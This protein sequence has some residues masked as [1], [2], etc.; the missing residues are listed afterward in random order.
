MD[1]LTLSL[2]Q[3]GEVRIERPLVLVRHKR[4]EKF[5]YRPTVKSRDVPL[6]YI[7]NTPLDS[8]Q[9]LSISEHSHTIPGNSSSAM[10]TSKAWIQFY[11]KSWTFNYSSIVATNVSITDEQGQRKPLF[12]VHRLPA[13]VAGVSLY[14]IENGNSISVDT[15]YY[16]DLS[17]KLFFTNYQNFFDEVS[18]SYKLFFLIVTSTTGTV[19]HL[20][21]NPEPAAREAT[22]EDIDQTTGKL[23]TDTPVYTKTKSSS[24]YLF[25]FVKLDTWFIRP[26]HTSLIQCLPPAGRNADDSW[27]LTFTNGDITAYTNGSVRRYYVPEF[28]RQAFAPYKPI[29]FSPFNK[30]LRVNSRVLK[31]TRGLVNIEPDAG[32]HLMLAVKDYEGN[33]VRVLS[34]DTSK[35]GRRYSDTNMMYESNLIQ[36]WDNANGFVVLGIDVLP[37]WTITAEYYYKAT[38][39]EYRGFDFNPI[40]N[41]RARDT[42]VVFYIVP[43]VNDSDSAIQHLVLNAE[44]IIVE[45]SQAAGVGL[46]NLRVLNADGSY[47]EDTVVGLRFA[48]SDY[49]GK[50]RSQHC[51]FKNMTL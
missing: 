45:A 27:Y 2:P 50:D 18:G 15:G 38:N 44:G 29:A 28:N 39:F 30:V 42:A 4:V 48:S 22:W 31:F 26:E 23:K 13:D 16:I 25:S 46:P 17:K 12:Y 49:E 9:N 41:E 7:E 11:G 32:L 36:T 10:D 5:V 20:L 19:Q 43:N 6:Y 14:S 1:T 34:T 37:S 40:I 47:N 51:M 33:L 3:S 8:T 21:L 35:H 24:G